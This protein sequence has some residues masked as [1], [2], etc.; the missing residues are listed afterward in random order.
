MLSLLRKEKLALINANTRGTIAPGSGCENIREG[1]DVRSI[2]R[3][4]GGQFLEDILARLVVVFGT[5]HG[6]EQDLGFLLPSSVWRVLLDLDERVVDH[7]LT[8]CLIGLERTTL[9]AGLVGLVV[10][11]LE[12]AQQIAR[13]HDQSGTSNLS[14]TE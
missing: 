10:A 9:V 6:V 5:S 11:G 13:M 12:G 4:R 1:F 2:G 14:K 7:H 3:C 8:H